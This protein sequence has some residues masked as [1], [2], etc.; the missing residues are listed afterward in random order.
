MD[1][2]AKLYNQLL[3]SLR[4]RITH[5][6]WKNS[7]EEKSFKKESNYTYQN[8]KRETDGEKRDYSRI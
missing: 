6:Y 1:F 3:S 4:K 5:Y 8:P 7:P 2:I